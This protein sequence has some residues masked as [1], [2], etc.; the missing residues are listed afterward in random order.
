M[1]LLARYVRGSGVGGWERLLFERSNVQPPLH[2]I[3]L[4]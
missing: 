2:M 4:E 3:K 1:T